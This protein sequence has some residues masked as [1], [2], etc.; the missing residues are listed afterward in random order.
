[1]TGRSR[2]DGGGSEVTGLDG[3]D[4]Q[5]KAYHN[6]ETSSYERIVVWQAARGRR[7]VAPVRPGPLDDSRLERVRQEAELILFVGPLHP[8][9][10]LDLTFRL[11]SAADIVRWAP[12]LTASQRIRVMK[13][14][15]WEKAVTRRPAA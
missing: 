10:D 15:P 14:L 1:M 7:L 3:G 2:P 8:I 5:G 13:A 9:R 6:C 11:H 12:N 4:P